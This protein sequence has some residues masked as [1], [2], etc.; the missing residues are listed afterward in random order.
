MTSTPRIGLIGPGIMGRPM[1]INL[2]NAGYSLS[3]YARRESSAAELLAAGA[4]FYNTPAKLA[5][6]SDIIISIVAD[7]PDVEAVLLG[8]NG[9]IEGAAEGLL[10]IDM[11]TIS[12]VTTTEIT[13]KLALKGIRMLDAPVS[14]GEAGAIAGTMTIMVGGE[15]VD[16]DEAY[17]VLA[18]MGKT[19]TLIG[20]H[21]AGQ[22]VKACN[23]MIIAQTIIAVSESFEMAKKA[24]VDLSKAREA[25]SGGFAG[26]K[27]MEIH[28]KRMIDDDYTPGF[29][30][31]LH[32][33]DLRIAASTIETYGLNLP[34]SQLAINYMQQLVDMGHGEIDSAALAKVVN[35]EA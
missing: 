13:E 20:G 18:A 34:S 14:G 12:P 35:K 21:G 24:G 16:F 29:K 10:V 5:K 33:K 26:S 22:I 4:S 8:E 3:V 31:K 25:L 15:Q 9:V 7:T 1:G 32:N 17:P 2:M 19:I 28:A 27:V 11:S 6:N 23:N 30:A